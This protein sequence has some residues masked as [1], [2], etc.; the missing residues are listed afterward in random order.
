MQGAVT[1][2]LGLV[3]M[4][5]AC[6]STESGT[7]PEPAEDG[8][9]VTEEAPAENGADPA[10]HEDNTVSNDADGDAVANEGDEPVPNPADANDGSEDSEGNGHSL[11][12]AIEIDEQISHANGVVLTV[13]SIRFDEELITIDIAA[14]NGSDASV[15]LTD[16]GREGAVLKDNTGFRYQFLP[17][18]DN[19]D[20]K[21][22][23]GERLSGSLIFIGQLKD[24][25]ASLDLV[26]NPKGQENSEYT[27]TPTFNLESIDLN[28]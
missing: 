3:L 18:E 26:F 4:I 25:A 6:G 12:E 21:I 11:P 1:V 9:S 10:E 15:Y 5:T 19:K 7:E 23:K 17:P 24:E 14:I 8:T 2:L 13:E 22:A 28:R 20:L 16:N 27:D